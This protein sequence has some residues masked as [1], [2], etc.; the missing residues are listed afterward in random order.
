[1]PNY[2]GLFCVVCL[3]HLLV[4]IRELLV[5]GSKLFHHGLVLIQA[6]VEGDKTQ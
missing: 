4:S 6:L 1:M 2:L 3:I 5:G